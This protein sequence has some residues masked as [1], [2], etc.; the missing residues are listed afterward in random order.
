MVDSLIDDIAHTCQIPRQALLVVSNDIC[1]MLSSS[2]DVL[3]TAS[4]KGL[5]AAPDVANGQVQTIDRN[6]PPYKLIRWV[7]VVEKEAVFN[8]LYEASIIKRLLAGQGMI[9]TVSSAVQPASASLMWKGQGLSR[10]CH[11][12]VPSVLS[13]LAAVRT[14]TFWAV[15]LRSIWS[16]YPQV[17]SRGFQSSRCRYRTEPARDEV[18]GDEVRRCCGSL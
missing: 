14:A 10:S 8:G 3:Q 6:L 12:T 15:R 18:V 4:P 11:P 16:R 5:F 9:V 2:D 17:L 1:S 7:L 13:R